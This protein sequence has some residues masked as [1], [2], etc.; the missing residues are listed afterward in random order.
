MTAVMNYARISQAISILNQ[1]STAY[2]AIGKKTAWRYD[3]TGSGRSDWL[4]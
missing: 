2:F 3:K 4:S 1:G